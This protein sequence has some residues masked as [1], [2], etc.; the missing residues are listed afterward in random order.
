MQSS[1]F[2]AVRVHTAERHVHGAPPSE[3]VWLLIYCWSVNV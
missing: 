1:R 2:A 3:E